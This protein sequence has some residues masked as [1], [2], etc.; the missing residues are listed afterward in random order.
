MITEAEQLFVVTVRTIR[1]WLRRGKE[2]NL[3][4]KSR[5]SGS[6]KIDEESLKNYIERHPDAYLREIAEQYGTTLQAIFYACNRLQITLKKRR[7]NTK[8]GTKKL[9]KSSLPK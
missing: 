7:R 2:G 3:A 6:Y 8:S 4:P 5:R 9:E 1:N